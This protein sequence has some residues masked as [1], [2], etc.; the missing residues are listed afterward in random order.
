MIRYRL[1]C[2]QPETVAPAG[3]RKA[4]G[5]A[6]VASRSR[7]PRQ[8]AKAD[9]GCGHEFDSWFQNSDAFETL[10]KRGQIACPACGGTRVDRAMMAPS[11]KTTKGREPAAA[12]ITTATGQ[13]PA[14]PSPAVVPADSTPAA[15]RMATLTPQQQAFVAAMRQVRDQILKTSE[16]VGAKFVEEARKIHYEETEARSIFGEATLD[17]AKALADEGIEVYP[18]PILPD[19]RN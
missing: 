4:S 8:P 9:T 11:V 5:K 2:L 3:G 15:M 14:G 1:I 10:A 16:N 17:D 7:Q 19:D 12:E 6:P 18:V 13:E